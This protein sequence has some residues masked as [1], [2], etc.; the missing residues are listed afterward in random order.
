MIWPPVVASVETVKN[1]DVLKTFID[2][3]LLLLVRVC[4]PTLLIVRSIYFLSL[5]VLANRYRRATP[6]YGWQVARPNRRSRL[7]TWSRVCI[8]GH[9]LTFFFGDFEVSAAPVVGI[10]RP[11]KHDSKSIAI[12]FCLGDSCRPFSRVRFDISLTQ[13][14][15][16]TAF[17]QRWEI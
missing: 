5:L 3:I 12:F 2:L 4:M 10:V 6:L 7:L 17:V 11:S 9:K 14:D 13:P 15:P 8:A 1:Y 16:L